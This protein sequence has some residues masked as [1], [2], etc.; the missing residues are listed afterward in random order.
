ML[1]KISDQEIIDT[2]LKTHS[3]RQT[4]LAAQGIK[5]TSTIAKKLRS[6][7]VEVKNHKLKP[8]KIS[9]D[10]LIA[11]YN[12]GKSLMEIAQL[13]SGS[14]GAMEVRKRLQKLGVDTSYASNIDK[15]KQKMSESFHKYTLDIHV[16]DVIDTEEKAYWFGFL[17][18]DGYNH[19]DKNAIYLRLQGED[20]EI[21][22]QFKKFLKSNAP[23]Y[24]FQR[25]TTVNHLDKEYCE[26]RVN[27]VHLSKQLESM[28]FVQAKTYVQEYPTCISEELD[29]HFIRGYFDG[30]G[31]ICIKRRKNRKSAT[32]MSYQ[33]TL[34]GREEFILEVQK[35]IVA[36]TGINLLSLK[37]QFN[38]FA[39]T[40]HY[41]GYNVVK[42]ILDY[43]YKD[44]TIYLKRKY[45]KYQI[46]VTRQS[47][48]QK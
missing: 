16:F 13:S 36:T 39:K 22:E 38:N 41:G 48:L 21:L 6:L 33:C 46:I 28:G 35:R 2:Y 19:V 14:K 44:A 5:S 15:Y 27:S 25:T 3:L 45:D 30:N 18:A 23:I 20:L 12:S 47:N 40:M 37:T 29:N 24:K 4:A 10:E 9:D 43:I 8:I 31:C 11:L 7:G 42:K 32:S 1:F 26:V 34:V 17:M